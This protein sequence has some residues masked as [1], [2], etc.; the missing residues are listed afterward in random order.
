MLSTKRFSIVMIALTAILCFGCAGQKGADGKH[1]VSE[2]DQKIT[3]T[4]AQQ[5]FLLDAARKGLSGESIPAAEAGILGIEGGGAVVEVFL[6]P[7]HPVVTVMPGDNFFE[8][9]KKAVKRTAADANF[10]AKM[11]TRLTDARIKVGVINSVKKISVNHELSEKQIYK[12]LSRQMEDGLNGF[13]MVTP[14]KTVYQ[15]PEMVFY[16]GWGIN[17]RSRSDQRNRRYGRTLVAKQLRELSK[18]AAGNTTEWKNAELYKFTTYTFIDKYG[19]PGT[20][21]LS[22]RAKNMIAPLDHESIRAAAVAN[23]DYLAR[24]V[25][26]SGKLVY[27]YFPVED[28][29]F[30]GYGIVRHAGSVFGLFES[31]NAFG[32]KKYYEAGR[33]ALNYLLDM[34]VVPDEAPNIAI[35]RERGR[36]VLGTNALVAMAYAAL[37]EEFMTDKD[38]ELQEK[39]GESIL[40]Y[41]MPKKGYFYTSF[42][43][44]VGKKAP[45]EQSRY[46]PGEAMLALVRLYEKTGDKKWWDAAAEISPGQKQRW[47]DAGHNEVGNYCWV[48]QAW[49]RMARLEKDPA[50]REEYKNLAYSHAD[51]VIKH[52][53]VPGHRRGYYP[54]YLGGAD[55]SAP[56]RTTPTSARGESLAENYLLAKFL[57]DVESQKKYGVAILRAL[58]FVIQNQFTNENSW[59]LPYP[60]KALG[61]I[62]GSL[63]ANDIR[64]D[65]NQHV[66]SSKINAQ[67]AREDLKALGVADYLVAQEWE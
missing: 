56:P 61:G 41:R 2:L 13:I 26:D 66:L 47:Q 65:Y 27:L 28:E 44:A 49:A 4:D 21:V 35:V 62:R 25:D 31:Y 48:G 50:M 60:H 43:Q 51:A 30:P 57:G 20:P 24:I 42:K 29:K 1:D 37:P 46:Y 5:A 9:F 58:H 6:S 53:F 34:T 39:L 45:K 15:I 63:I 23:A 16:D 19:Q 11:A 33:K 38:K 67:D 17:Y 12:R 64:I 18:E 55:N 36:S 3:F 22:R 8:D 32:D 40:Y 59:F 7:N 14:Q 52:Q 54:D 10:K